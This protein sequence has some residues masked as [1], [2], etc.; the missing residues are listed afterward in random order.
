MTIFTLSDALRIGEILSQA[1]LTEIT[2]RFG[3]LAA[4]QVREKSSRF[5]VVTDADEAAERAI[6][7]A[8]ETAYPGAVVVG[9]EATA[10]TPALLDAIG[11]ADLAFV[12]D[13]LDGTKNFASGLP[14]FGV[15][16]AATVRGDV[17]FAAIHDPVCRNTA[18]ALRGEG[19]WL[20][21]EGGA[22][23]DLKVA[24]AVPVREMHAIIGTNFLPEPLRTTVN[25]NLSRLGMSAWLRCAAHEYRM[26]AA[27][28][29]D[30]LFYNKLMPWDHAAGWLLH[31]EAGGYSAHFDGTAY[32]PTHVT[33]GLICAPDETSWHLVREALLDRRPA[34]LT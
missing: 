11:T 22:R 16:I 12:L 23:T 15:M 7:T 18:Y 28:H 9:E 8:L 17:V 24:A 19:A 26:A 34:P 14:L 10:K 6:S 4:G 27:G 1:S 33:G 25:G 13:P 3:E 5:D 2:P 21:A 32:H 31:R 29:C 20:Q 30:V